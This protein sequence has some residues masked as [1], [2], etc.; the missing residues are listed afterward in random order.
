MSFGKAKIDLADKYFSLWIRSRA[1]WTCERCGKY[2]APPTSAL[3]CSHFIGRGKENVRFDPENA[4]A[5]CYGCHQYFTSHPAEHVAWKLERIGQEAYDALRLKSNMYCKKDRKSEA[6]YW[7][8]KLK[9]DY[10]DII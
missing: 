7:K 3:H 1:N 6:M 2:Y 8:Q 5:H 10:P 4:S 9:E